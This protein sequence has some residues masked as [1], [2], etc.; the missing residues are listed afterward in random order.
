MSTTF[1]IAARS[2]RRLK[3]EEIEE[4]T[5]SPSKTLASLI[6]KYGQEHRATIAERIR[7]KVTEVPY[8]FRF[9]R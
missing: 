5:K 1:R 7:E 9:A 6:R 4:F 8:R 2:T 3:P